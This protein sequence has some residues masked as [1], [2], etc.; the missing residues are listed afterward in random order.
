M[1]MSLNP[2]RGARKKHEDAELNLI[3]MIDIM[4]VMVAFLLIYSTE[5]EVV[6]NAKNVQIPISTAEA[7]PAETVVVTITKDMLLV[8]GDVIATMDQIRDPNTALIEPL[9]EYLSR[10]LTARSGAA[11]QAALAHR[12]ITVL[13]DRGLPY[14]VIRK[15]MTTCTAAAYDKLSLA[16][17]EQG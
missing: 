9:R 16:V 14:E 17:L 10:P 2:F 13:A 8:Q 5:V 6:Q 4:S 1:R 7:K 12:E 11:Q 3:P 15:V